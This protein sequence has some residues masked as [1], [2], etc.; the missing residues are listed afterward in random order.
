MIFGL[1]SG[2]F[3]ALDTIVLSYISAFV[4]IICFFHDFIAVWLLFFTS[5]I[6]LKKQELKILILAG[7]AG[8]LGMIL[9]LL[10][11]Y[12]S[13]AS[14]AGV[15]S[16]LYPIFSAVLAHFVLREYLSLLGYFGLVLAIFGT[17]MLFNINLSEFSFLGA[18]CALGCA[19]CWGSECVIVKLALNKGTGEKTVL[20]IR[21]CVSSF[22][23]FAGI[24]VVFSLG[25]LDFSQSNLYL[26]CVASVLGTISYLFYYKAIS[27]LGALKAMGLN[28]SYSA[29]IVV[30]GVF[31][32]SQINMYLLLCALIII[33]GCLL[34][35]AKTIRIEV[36]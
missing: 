9:Y 23:S 13:S 36:K 21:Q 35:N 4:L 3:W 6:K 12:L 10:G 16:S 34:S 22:F 14:I 26:V 24:L 7:I 19:F 32:G 31:F 28:I 15:L 11:I 18:F 5:K 1:F 33:F 30:F 29:W 25:K 8:G 27:K 2:I 17:F 20:F